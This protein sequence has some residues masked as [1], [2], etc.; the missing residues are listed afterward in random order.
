MGRCGGIEEFCLVESDREVEVSDRSAL[1][2]HEVTSSVYT[3]HSVGRNSPI[4]KLDG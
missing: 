2:P 1:P 4:S 3:G